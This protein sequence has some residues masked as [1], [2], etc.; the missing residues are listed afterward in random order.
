MEGRRPKIFHLTLELPEPP[1]K[2]RC[3]HMNTHSRSKTVWVFPR[4]DA[5]MGVV[6]SC[7]PPR[8]GLP[9]NH[10]LAFSSRLPMRQRSEPLHSIFSWCLRIYATLAVM[11]TLGSLCVCVLRYQ[12]VPRSPQS[13][14]PPTRII[15]SSNMT[16]QQA[17]EFLWTNPSLSSHRP[18]VAWDPISSR[19]F[20]RLMHPS[21]IIP[22]YYRAS[23]NFENDDITVSTLISSDR[24]SVF[25]HLV[26]RYK[27]VPSPHPLC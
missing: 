7:V 12:P 17:E 24:F 9:P 10:H 22:Y 2:R 16:I 13:R 14:P 11:Y 18:F 19:A 27:G 1:Q 3:N 4:L 23:G 5:P 26:R 25:R 21:R 8:S 6:V 15:S 20:P